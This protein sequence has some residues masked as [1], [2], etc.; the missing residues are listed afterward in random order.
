MYAYDLKTPDPRPKEVYVAW[1]WTWKDHSVSPPPCPSIPTSPQD[2]PQ[3]SPNNDE[4]EV[5]ADCYHVVKF[6]CIGARKDEGSQTV[7]KA[8][9]QLEKGELDKIEVK[10]VPEPD[11][12]VDAKAIAFVTFW[13]GKWQRIGYVVSEAL[14]DV[15]LAMINKQII[16]VCFD[17]VKFRINWIR[18]G[19]GYYAAINVMKQGKWS[20]TVCRSASTL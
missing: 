18:S 20:P 2:S 1:K 7:L 12:P 16:N 11:N 13:D 14:D 3:H 10:M 4:T 8:L 15:H 5:G 17:W 9:A 6:K 19:I